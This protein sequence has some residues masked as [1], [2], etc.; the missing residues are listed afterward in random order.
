MPRPRRAG[1]AGAGAA[2][3]LPARP[4][5]AAARPRRGG[6]V[7][8]GRRRR[9]PRV[10]AAGHGR[11]GRR[12]RAG[13]ELASETG[14]GGSITGESRIDLEDA[15][16]QHAVGDL[17]V[18]VELVEQRRLGLEAE[19]A[20]VGLVA[21]LDLVGEL[22]QAP[23]LLGLEAAAR[24]DPPTRVLARSG[25]GARPGPPDRASER[26]R[27]RRAHKRRMTI[28]GGIAAIAVGLSGADGAAR[29]IR[30]SNVGRLAAGSARA[31]LRSSS[32]PGLLE[33]PE[34]PPLPADVGLAMRA[35]AAP[36]S[37]SSRRRR[38]RHRRRIAE[39]APERR[40]AQG[41]RP[42]AAPRRA[43]PIASAAPRPRRRSPSRSPAAVAGAARRAG[44]GPT[45]RAAAP[46]PRARAAPRRRADPAPPRAT[47]AAARATTPP[48]PSRTRPADPEPV[49]LRAL[50]GAR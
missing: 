19:E 13:G 23:G 12:G 46:P 5:A 38:R 43:R 25:R 47:R 35:P 9:G 8:S 21:L 36:T 34:P 37:R 48:D 7:G 41:G 31:A 44:H 50:R 40:P 6:G 32:L 30:W 11:G 10:V 15:E 2:R 14:G 45:A 39:R 24:L 49:R 1:S 3:R 27:I 20:V 17:Q 16:A 28:A 29:R 18:V 26:V 22:A 4:P 33:A 42:P